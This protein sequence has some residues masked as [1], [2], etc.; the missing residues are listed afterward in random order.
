MLSP[1][2]VVNA[3]IVGIGLTGALGALLYGWARQH[4][5]STLMFAGM[6]LALALYTFGALVVQTTPTVAVVVFWYK[7][8]NL[9]AAI[10]LITMIYLYRQLLSQTSTWTDHGL[11]FAIVLV[12]LVSLIRPYGLFDS[13]DSMQAIHLDWWGDLYRPIAQV[14]WMRLAIQI[15]AMA[16]L[17]VCLLHAWRGR[18]ASPAIAYALLAL[19]MLLLPS[20]IYQYGL[21]HNLWEGPITNPFG[22]CGMYVALT[23]VAF[24]RERD[25]RNEMLSL[26]R[27][28]S[29]RE[30]KLS[31]MTNASVGFAG[32]LDPQGRV[33]L[34]NR[35]ALTAIGATAKEI[36]GQPFP[37]TPWWRHDR[38]QQDRLRMAIAQ[39]ADGRPDGFQATH[40]SAAG[41]EIVVDF[42]LTPFRSA[43][44]ELR[45]LIAEGRDVT[46][47]MK[48][49]ERLREGHRLEAVGQL[50]GGVAHDFNNLL[51]AIMGAAEL[52][53]MR[54]DR[55]E[56]VSEHL[57]MILRSTTRA[58]DLTR[59]LLSF[60][61]RGKSQEVVFRV[62]TLLRDTLT[63][64][65]RTLGPSVR[66]QSRLDAVPDQIRGDPSEIQSA[67]LNL[68]LNARDAMPEGGILAITSTCETI[69]AA[70][71]EKLP[72]AVAPGPFIAITVTDT[73]AG[74]PPDLLGRI[75]EPF[76]T[77]KEPGRGTGLGLAAV[78]G[79]IHAHRGAIEVSSTPG[80][81]TAFTLYLPADLTV[82][83]AALPETPAPAAVHRGWA[84]VVDDEDLVRELTAEMLRKL[85]FEVESF[86]DPIHARQSLPLMSAARLMILDLAM[87]RLDGLTLY[88]EVRRQWPEVRVIIATGFAGDK[89]QEI[90]DPNLVAL[91]KPF[92]LANLTAAITQLGL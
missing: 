14:R 32:L 21:F 85:G 4:M 43:D 6:S 30:E 37:E 41:D 7:A 53:L 28:V 49:Q 33:V 82:T 24:V 31:A 44:G 56:D 79:A 36:V 46:A 68:A 75:F 73:G 47:L 59:N 69:D 63:V 1:L 70:R 57:G 8:M 34:A 51:A 11:S 17:L 26:F 58:A 54:A 5:R 19:P 42:S 10:F 72:Q 48:Y 61:R 25:R 62:N 83:D 29:E 71:A 65:T 39:A 2:T 52:A 13:I 55:Q 22:A 90:S 12:V 88:K 89:L 91:A 50:A 87:P 3:I 64:L 77:T 9:M 86:R 18:K 81:G 27:S 15:V 38:A 45:Y 40:H 67:V 76:F 35:A 60:S 20:L 66:V 80:K 84:V 16:A 23:T 74:I 78:L 92:R